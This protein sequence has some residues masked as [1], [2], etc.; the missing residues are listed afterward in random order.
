MKRRYLYIAY[1]PE[2]GD[3]RVCDLLRECGHGIDVRCPARGEPTPFTPDGY[4]GV[5]VGGALDD[6]GGSGRPGYVDRLIELARVC[7]RETVPFLGFCFGAQLL[8]AA[9]GGRVLVRAD[10]R[11]AFGYR[12]VRPTGREGR[13]VLG[14]LDHA[15]YL[16]YHGFEAPP[17]ATRL[18]A[19]DLFPDSAFR[20]GPNAFGFQFHPEIRADQV[21]TILSHLGPQAL[22][23][24][25]A[26]PFER[27]LDGAGRHDARV[28]DWLDGFLSRRLL[29][30]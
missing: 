9:G 23:R 18:A 25:G 11:G 4:H 22:E 30:A 12:P 5:I 8:A 27:H 26:D 6:V 19:G 2:W 13:E 16:H 29:A 1:R 28:H 10:G 24:R 20:L 7:L 17:A 14:G 3:N 15:Y 21:T